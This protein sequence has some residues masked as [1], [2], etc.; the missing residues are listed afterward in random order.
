LPEESAGSVQSHERFTDASAAAF[1]QETAWI[2]ASQRGDC[3]AFNRLVLKWEKPIYNL[4]LRMVHDPEEAAEIT[5]EVFLAA[6]RNI[7]HFRKDARFSTWLYR[8]AVNHAVSRLRRRP[9]GIHY[10]LDDH[11]GLPGI[12]KRVRPIASH[13]GEFLRE[14]G[15][16][17]V[18][19]ALEFL[20]PDQ[21]AVVE[22]KF[23]QDL[24][25]E[26]IAEVAQVPLSTIKSR[27][28]AGLEILRSRL[29]GHAST[30][31][32]EAHP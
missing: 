27:L 2:V 8:I 3:L 20:S 29:R 22:L 14:E 26:E 30:A 4:V 9:V 25:F 6:Y 16:Q 32:M 17:E 5:Q 24:T 13:E 1:G 18:R 21:K 7:T 12:E 15:R 19:R 23:F 28:Y 31:R 10:S 11:E